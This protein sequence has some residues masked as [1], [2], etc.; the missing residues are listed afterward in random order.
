MNYHIKDSNITSEK[1]IDESEISLDFLPSDS[2][3]KGK[4]NLVKFL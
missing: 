3:Y 2:K 1:I 4:R